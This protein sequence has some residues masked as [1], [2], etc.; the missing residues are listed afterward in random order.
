MISAG[1]PE[2]NRE[3]GLTSLVVLDEGFAIGRL[4][5]ATGTPSA[6]VIDRRGRIASE[7]QVGAPSIL[8]LFASPMNLAS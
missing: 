1:A 2:A 6:V 4:V 8:E 3:Q 7:V 5:G